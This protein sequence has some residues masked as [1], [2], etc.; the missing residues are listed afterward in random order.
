MDDQTGQRISDASVY[1][2]D[3]LSIVNT[4][5]NGFF[6]LKLKSKYR[7]ASITVSKE[8]YEDTTFR[9]EP[10]LNQALTITLVPSAVTERT[11]IVGPQDYN[12][13]E[14]INLEI[15][16]ND[17]VKWIYR[18]VK[19]DSFI[20]E[21]TAFGKWFVSSRQRIQSLNLKKFFVARPY[22]VSIVPGLSTNGKLNSQVVNN[23][24]LNLFGGYSGG[25]NGFELG[26]L[27]NIDKQNVK[28]AQAA[29][30]F[31][32][33]GGHVHGLQIGG[34]SNTVLDTFFGAQIG[35]VSNFV[36]EQFSGVQVAG[37]YNHVGKTLTGA[38]VAGVV[39]FT[40]HKTKGAQIAGIAN[41]SSREVK[42]AQVAG[43]FNY[44]RKL[45]GVQIG[46]INIADTSSGYSIGLINI[47]FKGYH[48]LSLYTNELMDVNAAFKTGNSKLYSI[49]LGG[50]NTKRGEKLWSY[51]YGLGTQIIGTKRFAMNLDLT[52][53]Q[54]HRGSW[55]H[56]NIL[57]RANLTFNLKI[58]KYFSVFAGPAYNVFVTNQPVNID[59][60]KP[61]I[62]PS[63]Y[64]L[65]TFG[66]D[67]KGW[68]GWSAG[69]NLF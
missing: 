35:G 59:G 63:N 67:V 45:S 17:S 33:V 56:Y 54:L 3:R 23:F 52:A 46:L 11:T 26:G 19:Q 39:N 21:K 1:E 4:D 9:I 53:Q 50:Y 34:V 37:V 47:V 24:S 66:N 55:D 27:F 44:T 38:Q 41:I 31:N 10:K 42:G 58:N 64:N 18:Y 6:K 43:V 60:Y 16:V 15:P 40:N 69:V 51:G 2:K 13:P 68:I 36:N 61:N 25:T 20:V 30:V 65:H 14:S 48:K 49:L 28:F 32:L 57:S 12:A 5:G 7:K 8:Y 29:G 62:P 22:Q